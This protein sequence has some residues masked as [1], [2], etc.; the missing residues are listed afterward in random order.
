MNRSKTS[1][2]VV[3]CSSGEEAARYVADLYASAIRSQ[4]EIV[5]GLATGGTPVDVYRE[6]VQQH[7]ENG[8]DF[9]SATSF[10]LDEYVG[11]PPEHSQSF[12]YF[13]QQQLFDHVNIDP[14]RTHV[15]DGMATDLDEHAEQYEI[16]IR[17]HGGID[18]QLLG[19]GNNGHIA[20][21]EPGS[22]LDS[23]TRVVQLTEETIQANARFFDSVDQVP[24]Q[25]ITMGIGTILEAR[26]I[27]LMAT[28]EAKAEAVADAI[29]GDCDPH[30]PASALQQHSDVV[31]VLDPAAASRVS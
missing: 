29:C 10:N 30:N 22:A 31:F 7:R 14:T 15:P 3:V 13:M 20:F 16:E 8:L 28:G 1:P 18:L 2:E 26:R 11:L 6:L 5:L 17:N 12:R 9:A 19:I 27:I 21:N 4:P 23:R 24:R 25:A